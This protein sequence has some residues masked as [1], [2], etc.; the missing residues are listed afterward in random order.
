MIKRKKF[1]KNRQ[2]ARKVAKQYEMVVR[3]INRQAISIPPRGTSTEMK[4]ADLWRKY[5]HWEKSNPL[6]TEEYGQLAKRGMTIW[7]VRFRLKKAYL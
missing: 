6:G 2:V 1:L 5:I 7:S 3:G 4:Q